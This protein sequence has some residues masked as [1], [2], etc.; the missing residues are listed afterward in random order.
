MQCFSLK[1]LIVTNQQNL[2]YNA[3][4]FYSN[5]FEPT[6]DAVM[7]F[8]KGIYLAHAPRALWLHTSPY[9]SKTSLMIT[10]DIDEAL[11]LADH[12]VMMTNGPAAN[13]GEIMT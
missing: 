1:N 11:F 5:G 4:R 10:H 9:N 13:I 7:L 8:V 3:H 6:S 2:D 12:L